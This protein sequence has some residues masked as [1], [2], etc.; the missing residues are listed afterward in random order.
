MFVLSP[1]ALSCLLCGIGGYAALMIMIMIIII[2]IVIII[3]ILPRG[4]GLPRKISVQS[5]AES[6]EV[7]CVIAPLF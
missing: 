7:E 3:F 2:I 1:K 5:C 4:F 6:S